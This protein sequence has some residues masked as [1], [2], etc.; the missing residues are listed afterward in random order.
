MDFVCCRIALSGI[1]DWQVA[2][3]EM[4]RV[5]EPHGRLVIVDFVEYKAKWQTISGDA[6]PGIDPTTIAEMLR[7]Y[8]LH[9][10]QLDILVGKATIGTLNGERLWVDTFLLEAMKHPVS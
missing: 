7:E 10:L 2:V 1:P 4:A 6:H 5:L 8:A 3:S 9:T